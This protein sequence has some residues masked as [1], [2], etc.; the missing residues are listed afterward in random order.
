MERKPKLLDPEDERRRL[1]KEKRYRDRKR[2]AD[3]TKKKAPLDVIDQLD[4]TS[5]F[6]IGS[7]LKTIIL[8]H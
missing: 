8:Y 6:G 1:E 5:I 3:K 4:A 7:R 2:A